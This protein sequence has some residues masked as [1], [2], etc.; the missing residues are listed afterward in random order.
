MDLEHELKFKSN[1]R[2]R[3]P[4]GKLFTP[5]GFLLKMLILSAAFATYFHIRRSLR[6]G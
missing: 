5:G 1:R 4:T 6:Q 2:R 3:F